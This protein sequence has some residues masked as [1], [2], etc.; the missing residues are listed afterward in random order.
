MR[1]G[2]IPVNVLVTGAEGQVAR[3][4]AEAAEACGCS[5]VAMGRPELD[6]TRSETIAGAIAARRPDVIVNAAAYTAVDKAES[7]PE[8]A[9]LVNAT[10]AGNV[11]RAAHEAGIPVIHIS[12]DYVYDGG[13]DGIYVET[14]ATAP[15]NT[16]GRTKLAGEQAVAEATSRH[17]I[18]RTS[19]VHSPFGNNFVKTMLR[20][21]ATRGELGVVEDQSGCPTYAPHLA[22]AILGIAKAL[23]ESG[24]R[25]ERWGIYNACGSGETTWAGLAREAFRI[26]A[27]I[28]GPHALVKPIT[29][30]QYPTPA[31]RPQ[32][33]RL[34]CMKLQQNFGVAL[35]DWRVGVAQ[36]VNRLIGERT[37]G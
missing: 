7:E 34:S 28:G 18:L 21:A 8:Q 16:Y 15:V 5:V 4:L 1:S 9:H 2:T 17:I 31:R 25:E 35:P 24:V 26:S 3:C 32:N 19:W 22:V 12:T 10:G 13:K 33:S 36:C 23:H 29:T 37:A 20:L 6:I 11:A 27:E 14:D 30:A